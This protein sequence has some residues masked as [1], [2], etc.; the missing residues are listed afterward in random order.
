M[1]QN[2]L[3][4]L[5]YSPGTFAYRIC[6][7]KVSLDTRSLAVFQKKFKF[8]AIQHN[9]RFGKPEFVTFPAS[10]DFAICN[11]GFPLHLM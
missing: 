2:D 7:S 6:F 10:Y 4:S 9:F 1:E 3:I 8:K 5:T 11:V